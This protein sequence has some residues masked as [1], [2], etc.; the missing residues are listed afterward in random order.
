MS[1]IDIVLGAQ[2]GDEGK[3]KLVDVLG[4]DAQICARAQVGTA[5]PSGQGI[6]TRLLPAGHTVIVD[7]VSYDFHLLPSGLLHQKCI[8][9]IGSGAV[10]HVPTFFKEM[11]DLEA[12]GLKNI[13]ERLLVSDRCHIITDCHIQVD[14]LEEQELGGNSIG[15][16]KRGIGPTYSTMAARNGITISE[17]FDEE[18]FERKL[19]Q[20]AHGFKKRFG[21]L[22]VY[23]VEDEIKRFKQYR[24]DLRTFVV[25]AVP[26]IADAQKNGN[27]ILV[28]GAQAVMLDLNFGTYPYVTS[29]NTGLGGV[30]T[31]L[32]LNPK[33]IN[34]IVG[35]VKSYTTR[36]GGGGFPT[37]LLN[38]TGEKLQKIGHEIGVSTGRS[39]RCGWLDLVVV[40]YSTDLNHYTALNLTKLD[41]LDTFPTIKVA[42][43]YKNKHTGEKFVSFPADL[44]ALED[45]EVVYEELE[46]W[47]TPTTGAKTYYDLPKQARTY[48]E[49]IEKFVGVKVVWIGTGPKR[50]DLIFRGY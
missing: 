8:S 35:V 18:L 10:V 32:G 40:K 50:E 3:G 13:R 2:W 23:D 14:G 29:S 48:I 25:D 44:K 30:F 28:E 42:V 31:G 45:A 20:L 39:R 24:E 6:L 7:G 5:V 27:K 43:A 36:V 22:L 33:K 19:R 17:M 15:T 4:Q 9:L 16:T 26:I 46:G 37:E 34:N 11:A 12:K 49:F 21:D 47:N 1:T 38:E 41:I